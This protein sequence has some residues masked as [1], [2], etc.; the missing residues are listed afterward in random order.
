MDDD[1]RYHAGRAL[2]R[3]LDAGIQEILALWEEYD[4]W[5][6]R[7]AETHGLEVLHPKLQLAP[8]GVVCAACRRPMVWDKHRR[9]LVCPAY[10]RCGIVMEDRHEPDR[11]V[12]AVLAEQRREQL[13]E[14]HRPK[15]IPILGDAK[16]PDVGHGKAGEK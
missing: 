13:R 8:G 16:G 14:M 11:L 7:Y 4:A 15:R 10:P 9:R 2:S 3:R 1:P 6:V 12:A 5:L